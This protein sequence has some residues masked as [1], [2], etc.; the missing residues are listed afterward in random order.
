[1]ANSLVILACWVAPAVF[2]ALVSQQSS[3]PA[4]TTFGRWITP[5]D[6]PGAL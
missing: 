2:V 5:P 1:M 3:L 4:D 6:G